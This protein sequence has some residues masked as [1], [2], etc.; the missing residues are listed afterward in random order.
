MTDYHDGRMLRRL[1]APTARVAAGHL[2]FS[3]ELRDQIR[4]RLL[5]MLDAATR[6]LERAEG[7]VGDEPVDTA[8]FIEATEAIRAALVKLDA[9]YYGVCETCEQTIPF[10][11]LDALLELTDAERL[12]VLGDLLHGEAVSIGM[13]MAFDFS[14]RLQLCP[15]GDA[16]LVRR[17]LFD[18][19]DF[20]PYVDRMLRER[21]Q[22]WTG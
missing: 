10:E 13:V 6:R 18:A 9:G 3:E 22:A 20:Q 12:L 5:G 1:S 14:V 21:R 19:T 11:R 4:E 15:P 7:E 17:H 8:E 2:G 16:A